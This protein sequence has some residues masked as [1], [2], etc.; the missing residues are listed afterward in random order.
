[1]SNRLFILILV[2]SGLFAAWTL[3]SPPSGTPGATLGAL[4]SDSAG[5]VGIKT[6]TPASALDVNGTTTIRASL[7]MTNNRILN[8]AIPTSSLDAANKAYVDALVASMNS[9]IKL[10]GEGR[11]G[12]SV[13]NNAGECTNGI[14]KVSRS[15]RLATWDGARAA[16]PANWCVCSAAERGVGVCGVTPQ[17]TLFCDP[18]SLDAEMYSLTGSAVYLTSNWGW[19]SDVATTDDR[20]AKAVRTISGANTTEEYACNI[21]PVWCCSY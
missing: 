19:V 8:V 14:I 10:W 16:C 6:A 18:T 20:K 4:F 12:A 1:M 5:N 11:P 7:D 21:A 15:T 13:A 3:A 2:G 17:P 9:T